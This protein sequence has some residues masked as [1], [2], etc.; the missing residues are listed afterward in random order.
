[1]KVIDKFAVGIID[2]D[3]RQIKYLEQ[4]KIIDEVKGNGALI[5]WRH[6]TLEKHHFIVQICPALEQWLKEVCERENID[7]SEFGENVLEGIKYHTKSTSRLNDPKL[8]KLFA[9]VNKK[10]DNTSI[11]KLKNWI[12][13]LREKNYKVDI[14][15]LING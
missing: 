15:E 14:N 8:Q 11:R 1:M 13:L 5:L 12:S 9:E 6:K 2:K 4:F 3:K 7:L 10:S